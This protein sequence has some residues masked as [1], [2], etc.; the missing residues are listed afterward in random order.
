M[1]SRRITAPLRPALDQVQ[2]QQV[3]DNQFRD[4]STYPSHKPSGPRPRDP[5]DPVDPLDCT[6]LGASTGLSVG[7]VYTVEAARVLFLPSK[8]GRT[9][10]HSTV[11]TG[12]SHMESRY[13]PSMTSTR[14]DSFYPLPALLP[15]SLFLPFPPSASR[16]ETVLC[17]CKAWMNLWAQWS[18]C[19]PG[20]CHCIKPQKRVEAG[21][22]AWGK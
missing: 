17:R 1:G 13:V 19:L 7:R 12:L 8:V 5:L 9:Y 22:G 4:P 6:G 21:R 16:Q 3:S 20:T 2:L 18:I 14:K 10:L 11:H 15:L